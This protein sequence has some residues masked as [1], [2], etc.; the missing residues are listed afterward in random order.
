MLN[1]N[2]HLSDIYRKASKQLAV[3]KRIGRFLTKHGKLTILN[4]LSCQIL[5]T[6]LFHGIFCSQASKNK[7]EKVQETLLLL[8]NAVP[9]HIGRTKLMTSEVF[10]IL[11]DLSPSYIQDLVKEKVSHYDLRNKRQVEIPQVNSKRYGIKS[12]GLR[13][14][15]CGTAYPMKS[16]WLRTTSNSGGCCRPGMG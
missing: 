15:R 4:H 14:P 9:L 6:A 1:F 7:M 16:D 13:Q 12:S 3:L 8:N 5:I 2:V 10:K 11:H